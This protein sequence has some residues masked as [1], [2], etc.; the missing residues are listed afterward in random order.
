[1][2]DK[3]KRCDCEDLI[4]SMEIVKDINWEHDV[5]VNAKK[6]TNCECLHFELDEYNVAQFYSREV[7]DTF[8]TA[9]YTKSDYDMALENKN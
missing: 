2:S 7:I 8:K 9:T 6:C 4:D 1:M 3:C 5:E